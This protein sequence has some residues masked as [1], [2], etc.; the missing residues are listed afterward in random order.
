MKLKVISFNIR[1]RDDNYG[2]A[3][4]ERAPRLASLTLPLD[5]DIIGFQEYTPKWEE[6]IKNTTRINMRY[7]TSTVPRIA[8]SQ[9]QFFGERTDL[10][11]SAKAIFGCLIPRRLNRGGGMS[12]LTAIEYASMLHLFQRIMEPLLHI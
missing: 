2:H 5:A 12:G 4:Y 1:C 9:R 10:I 8:T 6:H 3:I 11:C 7:S